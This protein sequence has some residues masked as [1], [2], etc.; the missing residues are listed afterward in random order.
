MAKS[1]RKALSKSFVDNHETVHE[2][3]A[4]ELI[5]KAEQTIRSIEEER[6]ADEKLAAAKSIVKD[7]GAGYTS[8]IKYERAKIQFLLEK[9]AEIQGGEVNPSSSTNR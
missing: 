2:D 5:V 1:A 9:I 4:A 7:L 3:M 8:A 6:E